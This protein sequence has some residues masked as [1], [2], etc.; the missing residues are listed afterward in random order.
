MLV[1]LATLWPTPENWGNIISAYSNM[2]K[3]YSIALL[4]QNFRWI[5]ELVAFDVLSKSWL[6]NNIWHMSCNTMTVKWSIFVS[7]LLVLSHFNYNVNFLEIFTTLLFHITYTW[8]L[9]PLV[10]L[11][12]FFSWIKI[13]NGGSSTASCLNCKTWQLYGL[14]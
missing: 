7:F 4:N 8:E 9:P 11:P 13:A 3:Q 6:M 5:P 14:F 2:N 12:A 10:V 1:L